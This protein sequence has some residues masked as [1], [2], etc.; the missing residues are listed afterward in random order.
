MR[1]PWKVFVRDI[2]PTFSFANE[3]AA[4]ARAVDLISGEVVI[5]DTL[6]GNYAEV[7]VWGPETSPDLMRRTVYRH[8]GT[9]ETQR[10]ERDPFGWVTI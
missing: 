8:D 9:T 2:G 5:G 10:L 4:R 3:A 7:L 1:R 6:Y